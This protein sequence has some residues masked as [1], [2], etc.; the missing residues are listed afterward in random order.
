MGWNGSG[1]FQRL[2]NWVTDRDAGNPIDAT[3]MDAEMDGMATGI[4]NC[5][6]KDGQN[7]ATA[8]I[9]LG[10]NKL[11]N[12]ANGSASGDAANF[13][14]TITAASY[15]D[16]AMTATLTRSAGDISL[17]ITPATATGQAAATDLVQMV[18][19]SGD[20]SKRTLANMF[21]TDGSGMPAADFVLSLD[22]SGAAEKRTLTNMFATQ[23]SIDS[24][25]DYL[26]V[27]NA[28]G[29][30]EKVLASNVSIGGGP[31]L[32]STKSITNSASMDFATAFSANSSYE[33]FMVEFYNVAPEVDNKPMSLRI[34]TDGSAFDSGSNYDDSIG[35][36]Q[37][38]IRVLSNLSTGSSSIGK[39][40]F[41]RPADTEPMAVHHYAAERGSTPDVVHLENNSNYNS[42]TA[43]TGF[44]LLLDS[45]F[46]A[47]G[48]IRVWGATAPIF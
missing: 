5:L 43:K 27:I 15:S 40:V 4:T 23:S 35:S 28:S 39:I 30:P 47:Q 10:S 46:L 20:S 37:T 6:A 2:Y 17:D 19:S 42:D 48:T 3:K 45:N 36:G 14:Q 21:S 13:G 31:V 12:V 16:T 8:N 26:M 29:V 25:A 1:V 22:A 9:D 18:D 33:Y 44:Q 34:S 24:S 32:L 41:Y 11:V 7:S 38:S